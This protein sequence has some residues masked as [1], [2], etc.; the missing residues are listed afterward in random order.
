M[1]VMW[2]DGGEMEAWKCMERVRCA[3]SASQLFAPFEWFYVKDQEVGKPVSTFR[4][5]YP[6]YTHC[7]WFFYRA[8]PTWLS[9]LFRAEKVRCRKLDVADTGVACSITYGCI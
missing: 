8:M 4:A 3:L 2:R 1:L 7:G 5:L 6:D 9:G